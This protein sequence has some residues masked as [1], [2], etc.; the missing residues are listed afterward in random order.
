MRP[1]A[2]KP[3]SQNRYPNLIVIIGLL[4][5]ILITT[6]IWLKLP[7]QFIT[8]L[9]WL[10]PSLIG[11]GSFLYL[12]R[13]VEPRPRWITILAVIAAVSLVYLFPELFGPACGGMPR[14]FALNCPNECKV[15]ECTRWVAGPSWN[16]QTPG[17]GEA[18]V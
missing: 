5:G 11:L 18:A 8:P 16:A 13:L 2:P 3:S 12:R 9:F 10:S 1:P 6:L 15:Q 17:P 4:S 14:A 7:N